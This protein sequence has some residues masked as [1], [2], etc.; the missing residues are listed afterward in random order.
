MLFP[1]QSSY[2]YTTL[3]F[4]VWPIA[5]LLKLNKDD[6]IVHTRVLLVNLFP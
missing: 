3:E 2:I 5:I 6:A 1:R 4:N